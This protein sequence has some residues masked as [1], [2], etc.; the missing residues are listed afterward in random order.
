MEGS[1]NFTKIN[2]SMD[3]NVKSLTTD[4]MLDY[5]EPLEDE[6]LEFVK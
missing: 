6:H 1:G 2:K 3:V 5:K 4:I